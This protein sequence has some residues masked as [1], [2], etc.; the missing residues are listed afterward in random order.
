MLLEAYIVVLPFE[1]TRSK[2][3]PD[4]RRLIEAHIVILPFA[5]KRSKD[6]WPVM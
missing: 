2:S 6:S 1:L 5:L 3:G 4:L